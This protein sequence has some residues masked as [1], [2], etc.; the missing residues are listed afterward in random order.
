MCNPADQNTFELLTSVTF[1]SAWAYE[2]FDVWLNGYTGTNNYFVIKHSNSSTY[3]TIQIDDIEVEALPTCLEP[4]NISV[5]DI[6]TTSA[7]FNWT[8]SGTA[9]DWEIEIGELG[10]VPG[11]GTTYTHS[12]PFGINQTYNL[13]GLTSA[14]AYDV[15]LR[16]DCGAGDYSTWI[17]PVSFLTSFDAFTSLP[18]TEDFE[19][20]MGITGNNY[21]NGQDWVINT[22]LQYG[23]SNSIHNPYDADADNVL[24]MLGTF[25]FT[26][27]TDVMLTFWQI[28]KTDGNY[29]HCY[30][31]ISTDGG[32]TYDQLPE[33]TY[34]GGGNYREEGLYNNP[35]GPCFDEDSY[36]DWGTGSETP[37]NSWWKKEY[38]DLTDYNTSDNVVI[39]FRLVSDSW[40]PK[41]G[42]FI[43]DI[44]VE[45]LGYTRI[46]C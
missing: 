37:D 14:T 4:I 5:S 25:D 16:S 15:Y 1:T 6:T 41:A 18:V 40:S 29:H 9:T 24:F 12:N 46:K 28:A 17:G 19:S 20:G 26:A 2:P 34:A 31:E 36:A 3:L 8:E 35:E 43:D 42:W 39:R 21:D 32:I 38:F 10:F 30:V 27:K 7:N 33:S 45:A 22:D 23:G 44:V 11:T 13:T